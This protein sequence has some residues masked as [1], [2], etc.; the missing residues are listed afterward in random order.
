MT[1]Y[2]TASI[3]QKDQYGLNYDNIVQLLEQLGHKVIH[4]HITSVSLDDKKHYSAEKRKEHY[5]Q[6]IKWITE[7]DMVVAEVSYPSTINVGHEVSI[8]LEKS[9]PVLGLYTK[10]KESTFFEGI[11][12]DKFLYEEYDDQ[13][14][15]EVLKSAIQYAQDQSDTRFN[16]FI[17]PKHVNYLDEIS[18]KRKI[19]KSVYLRELIER[20]KRKNRDY[21]EE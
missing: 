19:P 14:L 8:A 1:I 15:K 12:S 16:F 7:A 6:V 4:E 2:F 11:Q 18:R 20:D 13:N 9:K 5:R 21:T 3:F 10:E 17:F